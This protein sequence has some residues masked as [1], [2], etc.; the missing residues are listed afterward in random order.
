MR[1]HYPGVFLAALLR[2]QPMGFYSP[3]SLTA[4]A[5]RHGV[6]T[7]RPDILLSGVHAD[8]EPFEASDGQVASTGLQSCT[9]KKQEPVVPVFDRKWPNENAKH[10]RDGNLAVRLGLAGVNSIG[11]ATAERIVKERD[12]YG[13]YR[14]QAE[15][16]RRIGLSAQQLEALAAAGAFESFGL[17]QREALWNAGQAAQERPDQLAGTF[18]TVQPPLLPMLTPIEQVASDLWSMGISPDDH[19]ITHL[20]KRLDARGVLSYAQ[21][22]KTETGRRIEIGGVVIHRQRPATASGITFL[23]LEDETGMVNV[24]CSVGV[25]NRYRRVAREAPAMII[26]GILERS[27]EGVINVIADRFEDLTVGAK[28]KSRDFH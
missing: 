27:E 12:A 15:L 28:T 3:Q 24:V 17:T 16:A 18:V 7:L 9:C 21:L 26:R 14:S 8:M 22:E 11:A 5:A 20:R 25:W 10:R 4:D 6:K 19:P 1:L 13:P 2:A 23:N